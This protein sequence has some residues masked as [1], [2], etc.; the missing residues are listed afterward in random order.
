MDP[1]VRC[2]LAFSRD[3]SSCAGGRRFRNTKW[4]PQ[5]PEKLLRLKPATME[6][7]SWFVFFVGARADPNKPADGQ[8]PLFVACCEGHETAARFPIEVQADVEKMD[9]YGQSSLEIAIKR[10]HHEVVTFLVDNHALRTAQCQ[11][12]GKLEAPA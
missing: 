8:A 10:A 1:I 6:A 9:S 3:S 12:E 4:W 7:L 11:E 2:M 5:K